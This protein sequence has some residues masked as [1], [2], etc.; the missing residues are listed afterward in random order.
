MEAE[1]DVSLKV[2][3]AP[4]DEQSRRQ[5]VWSAEITAASGQTFVAEIAFH[6]LFIRSKTG[7]EIDWFDVLS[8]KE[9]MVL[10]DEAMDH[11]RNYS[12]EP[13]GLHVAA[14]AIVENPR[15]LGKSDHHSVYIQFNTRNAA[16]QHIKNCA[17]LHAMGDMD[18][19]LRL[20][21]NIPVDPNGKPPRQMVKEWH[22]MGGRDAASGKAGISAVTPC[23]F[24]TDEMAEHSAP[25]TPVF[26]H[27]LRTKGTKPEIVSDLKNLGEIKSGQIF[28]TT[29]GYLNQKRFVELTQAEQD[30][31][32]KAFDETIEKLTQYYIGEKMPDWLAYDAD[33]QHSMTIAKLKAAHDKNGEV[34]PQKMADI[35]RQQTL[36]TLYSRLVVSQVEKNIDAVR[37][38]VRQQAD[39]LRMSVIQM[40]DG[41]YEFGKEFRGSSEKAMSNSSNASIS[42]AIDRLPGNPVRRL[43][44]YTFDPKNIEEGVMRTPSKDEL[45]R[46]YKRSDP[47]PENEMKVGVFA[48]TLKSEKA[49]YYD[50]PLADLYPGKFIGVGSAHAGHNCGGHH[51]HNQP[52]G[53]REYRRKSLPT[54]KNP[55]F[56]ITGKRQT[57]ELVIAPGDGI[58]R[59]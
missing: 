15:P 55:E 4:N 25:D 14:I 47:S 21:Q 26:V 50:L 19:D 54:G 49:I 23:G 17:E 46:A 18:R 48:P 6:R 5:V 10:C 35:F 30:Q 13:N 40:A 20:L 39:M 41:T 36:M 57:V 44:S 31:Q 9:R 43:Y 33:L 38:W 59:I 58:A 27:S 22:V 8:E 3:D 29:M 28:K 52:H 24:C 56:R 45:E 37:G 53:D 16:S 51:H 34:D 12:S 2:A 1:S 11:Y 32:R 7:E 42:T